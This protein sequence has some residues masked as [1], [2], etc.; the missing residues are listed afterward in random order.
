MSRSPTCEITLTIFLWLCLLGQDAAADSTL[1]GI[2][3]GAD[4]K[5][6]GGVTVYVDTAKPR[7]GRGAL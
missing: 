2:V 6:V 7:L 1:T 3:V 4:D 5:P